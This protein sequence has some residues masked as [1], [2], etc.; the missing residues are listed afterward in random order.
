MIKLILLGFVIFVCLPSSFIAAYWTLKYCKFKYQVMVDEYSQKQ[1]D[2]S[3]ENL[4][5]KITEEFNNGV[6]GLNH[7]NP[8]RIETEHGR[9]NR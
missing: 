1:L 3:F 5:P 2:K 4:N 8:V 9:F 6:I 7:S